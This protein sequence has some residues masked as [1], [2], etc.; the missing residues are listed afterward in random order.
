MPA[1]VIPIHDLDSD[2]KDYVFALDES[3]LRQAFGDTGVRGDI[4][5]AGAVEVHAQRNGREILVH[6]RARAWLITECGRCL[7]E[8]PVEVECDLAALYAPS[9]GQKHKPSPEDEELD[10]DP[11]EPDREFY[12]GEQVAIDDLVRDY[13]LLELP[14]QPRCDLGWDCPNLDLPE[15]MRSGD[16]I[17]VGSVN[18]ANDFGED[19]IDPRLMPLKKL[20]KGEPDKE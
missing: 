3:W 18:P 12:S 13:L 16:G 2:G 6:G 14:M 20:V 17:K 1:L 7:Q 9:E 4:S 8:L 19:T 5:K 10:I 11:D 15:H